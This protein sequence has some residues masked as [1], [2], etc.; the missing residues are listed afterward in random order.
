MDLGR[1]LADMR[2]VWRRDREIL[3]AVAG[4]F[5]FL[6]TLAL[7][8]L[9]PEAPQS[10]GAGAGE[11]DMSIF[12]D[13]Y[14]GWVSAN[15][16]WFGLAALVTLYGALTLYC[17][18]LDRQC[19]DV[20]MA[21]TRALALLPRYALASLIVLVPAT[22]GALA[23]L[24]PGLYV[25]G[26]TMLIGP[27]LVAEK[28]LVAVASV[29]RSVALTRRNGLSLLAVA[30]LGLLA[31]QFLPAPFLAIDEGLRAAGAANPIVVLLLDSAAAAMSAVVAV[32][33]ILIRIAIYRQ[34]STGQ[35]GR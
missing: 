25:L 3:I 14:V 11:A 20:R 5:I 31:G 10:P 32:S 19:E 27:A 9:V 13:A 28:P 24:V 29:L 22:V 34:L 12:I 17:L 15:L 23:F 2:M 4:A 8:L 26:R 35:L 1:A 33:I 6:P 18:Y 30:T 7:L 21:L 16:R